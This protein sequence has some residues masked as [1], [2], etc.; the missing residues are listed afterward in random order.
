MNLN[1]MKLP[2]IYKRDNKECYLDPIR[3]K[4]IYIT[5]E[6]TVRQE[7]ISYLI[8]K[9]NVPKEMILVEEHLSHFGIKSTRRAD[10][11]V[12]G[13][14]KNKNEAPL[15]VIECKAPTVPLDEKAQNQMLDYTNL[16][17]ADYAFLIN[18]YEHIGFKYDEATN[19]YLPI[20]D[21]PSY[22]EML[23]GKYEYFDRGELPPRIPFEKLQVFLEEDFA[24]LEPDQ[25][26]YDI[27]KLTPM[28]LAVP[29]FNILKG[30]M[31]TRVK[32]PTGNYGLFELVEDYGVR[33]LSY[34]D[35]SGGQF[36]GPYRSF[37]VKI[38][39]NTEIFSLAFTTY[40]SYSY[41]TNVRTCLCVAHDYEK[42][43]HHSLLLVVEDNV[44]RQGDKVSFFHHGKIAVGN[45]GSGKVD[46]LRELVN[47]RYPEII[48]GRQFYL[49]SVTNDKLLSLDN[50]EM[51]NLVKN[52]I[53][54]SIIRDEYRDIVKKRKK[55]K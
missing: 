6:E 30:L 24:S 18:G 37:L 38:G 16:I 17:E 9:L 43:A 19:L 1:N 46:E 40:S 51:I 3:K 7:L 4:L 25:Y 21:L 2:P 44:K 5:P 23:S 50:P 27:S 13:Y 20:A 36:F 32:M 45:I 54:Y 31:D 28:S 8:N 42:E 47:E 34:G 41:P 10:I 29:M 11:V 22:D 35:A 26:G 53:S 12:L 14:D 48:S 55:S 33:M 52:L 39:D 15:A 49:G